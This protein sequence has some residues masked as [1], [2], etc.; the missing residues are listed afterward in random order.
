MPP[1]LYHVPK[2]ISSPI[3]QILIELKLVDNPIKIVT[4]P[5]ADLKSEEHL[6][7]NPMGTSPTFTDTDRG[8]V[9][10]ESGAILT[11]LL[12][13]YDN[14][15]VLHL[16]ASIPSF[17]YSRANNQALRAKFLHIQQYILATVYPFTASLYIHTLK[18]KHKQDKE[19]VQNGTDKWRTLMGPTL[20]KWLLGYNDVYMDFFMGTKHP[21][22]IDFLVAKPLSNVH[23]M[24]LLTSQEFPA[25]EQ[26]FRHIQAMCSFSLA[27]TSTAIGVVDGSTSPQPVEQR[28][29]ILVP[30][31][32]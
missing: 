23:S 11:Y 27:Y 8:I 25:L 28:E 32:K 24:G 22:A 18:P 17:D 20:T 4:M 13:S 1:T 12:E 10:W 21:T 26:L 15:H 30:Q 3:V 14:K 16:P 29:L 19:Y 2:T 9:M 31:K 5:F 7:R 6:A